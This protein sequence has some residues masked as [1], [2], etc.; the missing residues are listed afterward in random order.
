MKGVFNMG[1]FNRD[2]DDDIDDIYNRLDDIYNRLEALDVVNAFSNRL[3]RLE[4]T[5]AYLEDVL[6]ET[7]KELEKRVE[8]LEGGDKK[9]QEVQDPNSTSA[10]AELLNQLKEMTSGIGKNSNERL[11]HLT[12]DISVLTEKVHTLESQLD[13]KDEQIKQL[14]KKIESLT[15]IIEEDNRNIKMV[16]KHIIDQANSMKALKEE[17]Y[18]LTDG[19]KEAD[20]F[21]K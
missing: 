19:D 15:Y 5:S 17:L 12:E 6:M 2:S 8:T 16:A 13:D 9:P 14:N 10:N 18:R 7:V 11:D 20:T 4:K 1:W 3:S 21:I